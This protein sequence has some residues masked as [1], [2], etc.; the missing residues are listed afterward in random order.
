MT[1]V[2]SNTLKTDTTD[3]NNRQWETDPTLYLYLPGS[4]KV[5]HFSFLLIVESRLYASRLSIPWLFFLFAALWHFCVVSHRTLHLTLLASLRKKYR[6]LAV[7]R[8]EPGGFSPTLRPPQRLSERVTQAGVRTLT[9]LLHGLRGAP[10]KATSRPPVWEASRGAGARGVPSP[11]RWSQVAEIPHS[12]LGR[13]EEATAG[14]GCC[15]EVNSWPVSMVLN[16]NS[17]TYNVYM[18][19]FLDQVALDVTAVTC[20]YLRRSFVHMH[21]GV[22]WLSW[23]LE[24]AL[25]FKL[26]LLLPSD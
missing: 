9:A 25:G 14:A 15:F 13:R 6:R 5:E 22:T 26:N 21:A 7:A 11:G 1:I 18:C 2:W 10:R 3:E 20:N 4:N 16:W 23:R 17:F 8:A 19:G 12:F 24:E